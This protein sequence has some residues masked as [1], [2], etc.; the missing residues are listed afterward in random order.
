MT[1]TIEHEFKINEFA[2]IIFNRRNNEPLG[3]CPGN[4]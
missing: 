1:V 3:A 2:Y 4:V